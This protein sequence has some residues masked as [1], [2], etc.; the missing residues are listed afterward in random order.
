MFGFVFRFDFSTRENSKQDVLMM[1]HI[2]HEIKPRKGAF[3]LS[4]HT[5]FIDYYYCNVRDVLFLACILKEGAIHCRHLY[6]LPVIPFFPSHRY[7]RYFLVF[8]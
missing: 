2:F 7:Y 3:Q 5:L 4:S 8:C 1:E 6:T